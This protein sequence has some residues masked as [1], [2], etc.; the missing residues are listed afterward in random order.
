MTITSPD[1]ALEGAEAVPV[2]PKAAML[3]GWR[4]TWFRFRQRKVA[5]VALIFVV[6]ML[7]MAVLAPVLAPYDPTEQHLRD[8]NLGFDSTYLLG[9]DDLGRDLLSR[10]LY[11]LRTSLLASFIAVCIAVTVGLVVG[12]LAGYTGKWVDSLLMRITDG[13]IAIPSLLVTMS[14]VSVLGPSLKSVIVGLGVAFSPSFIR[15]FRAQVLAVKEEQFVEAA[16]V[17]GASDLRII[18]KHILPNAVAPIIV[19]GLMAMGLALLAEGALSYL[20]L[21]VRPPGS[22]LGTILQ[23]GFS[24]KEQSTQP[25]YMAGLFITSL[26]WAFNI[27]ADGLRD[28]IGRGELGGGA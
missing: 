6:V 11:G 28:A 8:R 13:F 12:V 2:L 14:F 9:T 16:V 7:A 26:S 19:Q 17:A 23:R 10:L 15:L 4:R 27:V 20:G 24:F 5:L 21:S 3:H 22:S 18:R 1:L 25:I